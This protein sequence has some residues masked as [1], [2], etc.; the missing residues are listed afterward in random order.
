MFEKHGFVTLRFQL[1]L[2]WAFKLQC[3]TQLQT[4][5]SLFCEYNILRLSEHREKVATNCLNLSFR[6]SANNENNIRPA[7]KACLSTAIVSMVRG[8]KAR[9]V[10]HCH[11]R[12]TCQII[13]P[14]HVFVSELLSEKYNVINST[15]IY[16]CSQHPLRWIELPAAAVPCKHQE[17]SELIIA[18][19]WL[20]NGLSTKT[21]INVFV[22]FQESNVAL[23]AVKIFLLPRPTR[24]LLRN[25]GAV[26]VPKWG[27]GS[28][29]LVQ[30][31]PRIFKHAQYSASL[32]T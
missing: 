18:S 23:F 15:L 5:D 9:T 14:E 22:D 19:F 26:C 12:R 8:N 10:T 25:C 13:S 17:L 28:S 3:G 24:P 31:M 6:Q 27:K 7:L 30:A 2:W 32:W 4:P 29:E 11:R 1:Y 20:K 21:L 16:I